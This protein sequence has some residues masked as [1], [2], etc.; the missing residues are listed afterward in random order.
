MSD[1]PDRSGR[2]PEPLV[3]LV[4]GIVIVA[5]VVAGVVGVRVHHPKTTRLVA[6]TPVGFQRLIDTTNH[7][8]VAVPTAWKVLPLST[9][10]LKSNIDALKASSPQL[11]PL[12]ALAQSGLQRVQPGLFAVDV[13]TRTSIFSYGVD[14]GTVNKLQDIPTN[15]I[16]SPLTNAG[17]RKV[18]ATQIRLP[19]GAAERVTAQLLI[20]TVT[21]N[22]VLDYFVLNHRVVAIVLAARDAEPPP[23]LVSQ[24]EGSLAGT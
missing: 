3:T 1:R 6:V 23:K 20:G 21:V 16:T 24:I 7:L 19:L 8:S 4:L 15:S 2:A 18:T 14:A 12:L 5:L 17:A 9:G 22:E 13:N 10:Q 11:T